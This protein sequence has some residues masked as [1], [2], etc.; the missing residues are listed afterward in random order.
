MSSFAG[1]SVVFGILILLVYAI[2]QWLHIPAGN[3]LDWVIG[4]ATFEWLLLIVTVPW[5]IHF[6]SK[7]VLAE[8]AESKQ[9]N[10]PVD[11][12]QI[13]YVQTLANRSLLVAIALHILSAIGLYTLAV[14]G[15]SAVG[16]ISSGAALLLTVLRPAIRAYKY[17]AMRLS[18]IRSQ[19]LYPREDILELRSRFNELESKVTQIEEKLNPEYPT[20][21]VASQQR[22]WEA[23]QNELT[24]VAAAM[25]NLRSTNKAE[26][27]Q[28]AREAQNAIAQ[29]TTDGQ[30]LNHVRE[31]I[32]F[33]KEA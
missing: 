10:I 12:K 11:E 3:F 5:N 30:F 7:S 16:Y 1:F 28:L 6:E 14:T 23:M 17:L 26:H 32:R 22:Q 8:A 33:F 27:I 20:S 18:M 9:K 24:V 29:L 4:A 21:W 13:N 19:F 15:I 31:I 25:E 2:L